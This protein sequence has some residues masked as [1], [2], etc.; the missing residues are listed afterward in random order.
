[1]TE[2]IKLPAPASFPRQLNP[3]GFLWTD[4]QVEVPRGVTPEHVVNPSYW[5]HVAIS[6]R[7]RDTITVVAADNSFEVKLRVVSAARGA[8][9]LR[10]VEYSG[11]ESPQIAAAP[12]A[13][14]TVAAMHVGH[15]PKHGWRVIDDVTKE[16][17]SKGHGTREDAEAAMANLL[18]ARAA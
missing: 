11:E 9:R 5:Q 10:V 1:M 18:Q 3:S 8:L 17:I 15:A 12:V 6:L 2:T 14:P 7:V 4:W 13:A 16:V